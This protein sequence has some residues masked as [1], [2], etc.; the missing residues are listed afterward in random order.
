MS[1][2]AQIL[3]TDKYS[4]AAHEGILF[5]RHSDGYPEGVQQSLEQFL[6]MVGTSIR[7]N[8][9]QAAGWLVLIG[10]EE[11]A[12]SRATYPTISGWKVGAYE[13]ATGIHGDIEWFYVVNLSDKTIVAYRAGNEESVADYLK[14]DDGKPLAEY[15]KVTA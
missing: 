3:V 15:L 6:A 4:I 7:N 12:E 10:H 14:R 2:R 11:Y 1:T 9:E 8:C 13:P 5:Y